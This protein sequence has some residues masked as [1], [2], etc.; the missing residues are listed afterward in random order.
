MKIALSLVQ[1]ALAVGHAAHEKMPLGVPVGNAAQ[2]HLRLGQVPQIDA[3]AHLLIGGAAGI[4]LLPLLLIRAGGGPGIGA[5]AAAQ[6][7]NGIIR[8]VDFLHLL[9]GQVGQRI[10]LVVVGMV[11]AGQLPVGALDFLVG[12]AGLDAQHAV[13]IVHVVILSY[14]C[15]FRRA[16]DASPAATG[17]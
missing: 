9:L 10:V 2:Q 12:G 4:G 1:P 8:L 6:L 3:L 13:R 15:I 7:L 11:F 16:A 17:H 14:C 5:A